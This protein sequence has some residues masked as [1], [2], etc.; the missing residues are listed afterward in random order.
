MINP[1]LKNGDRIVLL[2]M[3]DKFPVP[4]L[5]KGT[6]VGKVDVLKTTQYDVEWDNGSKLSV[7]DG[8]DKWVL[9]SDFQRK[10]KKM[11]ENIEKDKF[12]IKNIDVLKYFKVKFL[13]EYLNFVRDS[14]ITNMYG[15]APYLYMGSDRIKHEFKYQPIPNES[16]FDKVIEMAD[17]AQS[18]MI[19]GVFE[20]LEAKNIDSDMNNINRYLSRFSRIILESYIIMF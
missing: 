14:G 9:L 6:V 15:A 20:Y 5:T 4:I 11:N 13:R 10:K 1:K 19:N 12:F 17:Q 7:I 8:I 16:A 3:E 2:H 18:E